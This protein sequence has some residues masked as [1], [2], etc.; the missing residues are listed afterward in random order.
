MTGLLVFGDQQ[1]H[2]EQDWPI[3]RHRELRAEH[4][5]LQLGQSGQNMYTFFAIK[6]YSPK[7]IL[8]LSQ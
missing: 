6:G 1:E 4:R 3:W 5:S 7:Y 8:T 2:E